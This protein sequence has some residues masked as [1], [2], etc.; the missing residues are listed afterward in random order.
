MPNTP[1]PGQVNF[2][3]W[4][5]EITGCGTDDAEAMWPLLGGVEQRAWEA[6]AQAVRAQEG[7]RQTHQEATMALIEEARPFLEDAFAGVLEGI[8]V[9]PMGR[10]LK[11]V[12]LVA[13]R[14]ARRLARCLQVFDETWWLA[15]GHRSGGNLVFDY[16]TIGERTADPSPPRTPYTRGTDL[17]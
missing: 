1:T 16:E 12:A 9:R 6:A 11:V 10:L 14:D 17:H 2:V 3:V 5:R 13:S 4:Q 7:G 15:N 8:E